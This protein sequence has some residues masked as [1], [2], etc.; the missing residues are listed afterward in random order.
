MAGYYHRNE[1]FRVGSERE[2]LSGLEE[3]AIEPAA[4]AKLDTIENPF[5]AANDGCRVAP[6]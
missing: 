5:L 4:S 2:R 1:I 6:R 3:T